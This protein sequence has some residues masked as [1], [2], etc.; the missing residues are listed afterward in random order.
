VFSF[1]I[2]FPHEGIIRLTGNVK[3]SRAIL[4]NR[5]GYK[6]FTV[7]TQPRINVSSNLL[8]ATY[9]SGGLGL[10]WFKRLGIGLLWNVTNVHRF[11]SPPFSIV[12][13]DR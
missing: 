3:A 10:F 8:I 9:F 2:L 4:A 1:F 11:A 12:L 7:M 6:G 13:T 5:S